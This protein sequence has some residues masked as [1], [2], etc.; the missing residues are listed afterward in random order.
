MVWIVLEASVRKP[1][2][3]VARKS[4]SDVSA[5]TPP[6]LALCD[7][8]AELACLIKGMN[9]RDLGIC[10]RIVVSVVEKCKRAG[11]AATNA[12]LEQALRDLERASMI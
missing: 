4:P 1:I 9:S 3:Y 8:L 11:A 12:A 7:E 6:D 10:S 5:P 2:V